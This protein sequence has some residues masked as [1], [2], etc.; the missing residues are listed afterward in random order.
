MSLIVKNE[1]GF[2]M[3]YIDELNGKKTDKIKFNEIIIKNAKEKFLLEFK[4]AIMRCTV[5]AR[6]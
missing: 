2:D 3:S 6:L 5:S 4:D 1:R